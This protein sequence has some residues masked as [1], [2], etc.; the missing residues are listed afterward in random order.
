M[1]HC[2]KEG[3]LSVIQFDYLIGSPDGILHRSERHEAGLFTVDEMKSCF[4]EAGLSVE[5]EPE[6]IFGRGIYTARVRG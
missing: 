5:H 3:R 4:E 6:G 1:S 2:S